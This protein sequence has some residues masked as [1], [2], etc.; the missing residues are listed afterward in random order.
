MNWKITA[1]ALLFI[2]P[3]GA[4]KKN[5]G[6]AAQ[7]GNAPY[8]FSMVVNGKF[9]T[10]NNSPIVD[11][12]GNGFYYSAAGDSACCTNMGIVWGLNK[13]D[14]TPLTTGIY[15]ASGYNLENESEW[16]I[17][18]YANWG[19]TTKV[20]FLAFPDSVIVTGITDSTI[21]GT[22]SGTCTGQIQNQN[23]PYNTIDSVM[24]VSDGKFHLK[25]Y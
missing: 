12:S 20:G 7:T 1:F 2:L 5:G 3:F 24:T 16:T 14:N 15:P 11:T 6:S 22:F 18:D 23:Y 13:F 9:S 8:G 19:Y 4:C 10:F 21:T 17:Y 25:R